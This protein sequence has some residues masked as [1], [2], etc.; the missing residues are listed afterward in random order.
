MDGPH[1]ISW[2]GFDT[3]KIELGF[4]KTCDSSTKLEGDK[5]NGRLTPSSNINGRRI[6]FPFGNAASPQSEAQEESDLSEE[7]YRSIGEYE[8]DP[9]EEMGCSSSP[10]STSGNDSHP[11]TPVLPSLCDNG[12]STHNPATPIL[13]TDLD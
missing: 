12:K 4:G 3:P 5:E 7:I 10:T 6:P 2:N 8:Y 11:R 9:E 13:D 1:H